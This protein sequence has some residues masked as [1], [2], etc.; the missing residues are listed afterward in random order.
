M[1]WSP[2]APLRPPT[3]KKEWKECAYHRHYYMGLLKE[4]GSP[5]LALSQF[6]AGMGICQWFHYEDHRL[7]DSVE[8]LRR[9]GVNY[10]RIGLSWADS[11][12]PN[13]EAWID[14]Q[15][16]AIEEFATNLTLYFTP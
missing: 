14:R 6:P 3:T 11:F 13:A 2:R 10:L 1:F 8:W 9:L 4:D 12:R 5:K 15:I 16:Q 7:A